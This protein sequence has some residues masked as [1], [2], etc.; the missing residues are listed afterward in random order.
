MDIRPSPIAGRWYP[1]DASRLAQSID[2]YLEAAEVETPP[3]KWWA[4][5][6]RMPVTFIPAAVAA[7]AYQ[8]VRRQPVKVVAIL[9]PSHF[10][11]DGALITTSHEA[12]STPLGIVPVDRGAVE[13]LAAELEA[14]SSVGEPWLVE[15]RGRPRTRH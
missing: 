12:Y 5:W 6:C 3:A 2:G 11:A 14:S 10:H 15:I 13:A 7:Y 4:S 1:G 9:C 8:A